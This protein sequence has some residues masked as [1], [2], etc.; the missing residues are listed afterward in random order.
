VIRIAS[1]I[2][3]FPNAFE[4]AAIAAREGRAVEAIGRAIE[5]VEGANLLAS[6]IDGMTARVCQ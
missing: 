3:R 5:H 6:W 2:A 4:A 1:L